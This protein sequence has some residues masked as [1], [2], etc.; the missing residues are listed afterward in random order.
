[1]PRL[2]IQKAVSCTHAEYARHAGTK[3]EIVRYTEDMAYVNVFHGTEAMSTPLVPEY[4]KF[5]LVRRALIDFYGIELP[6][7]RQLSFAGREGASR[8]TAYAIVRQ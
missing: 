1:M 6:F 8:R 2:S 5:N 3:V 7:Q 4:T